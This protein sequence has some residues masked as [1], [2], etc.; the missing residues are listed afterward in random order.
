MYIDLYREGGGGGLYTLGGGGVL[1]FFGIFG[2]IKSRAPGPPPRD[3]R[4]RSS[5]K[6]LLMIFPLWDLHDADAAA[7][8]IPPPPPYSLSLSLMRAHGLQIL[9]FP[10]I[11]HIS[12]RNGLTPGHPISLGLSLFIS[13][14]SVYI[15]ILLFYW[16]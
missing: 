15:S 11:E 1:R 10:E 16:F 9:M 14:R 7:A 6:R 13:I 8:S 3:Y 4:A 2:R 5:G 12:P